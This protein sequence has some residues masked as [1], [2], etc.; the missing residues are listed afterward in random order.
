MSAFILPMLLS[1]WR[2]KLQ[3]FR[4]FLLN[5]RTLKLLQEP[6]KPQHQYAYYPYCS[7]YIF[8]G[9]D[10]E[11]LFNNQEHPPTYYWVVFKIAV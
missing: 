6:F 1:K 3:A 5:F 4:Q 11:N 10:K 2:C 8:K 7:P 9:A